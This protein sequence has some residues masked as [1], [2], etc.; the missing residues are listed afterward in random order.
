MKILNWNISWAKDI[1]PKIEC[2]RNQ[3]LGESFIVILQEVKP[4]AYNAIK[5]KLSD[6]ARIEYSL[7]YRVPSRYD[8]DSRK[9]GV[10]ILVSKD[11]VIEK[12]KVL[13]RALMPDRTL[14]VDVCYNNL[15]LRV[16]GLHSITGCQH[17]KAKEI[18]YFSFAEAID[19]YKP[20]VVGIDANEPQIDHYDVGRMKFFD[21]H[22][23]G[24]GCK[25]FFEVMTK[26]D[27]S[28]AYVKDYDRSKFVNGECLTTSHI[29]KRGRKKV[30]YDFLFI[31]EQ[32]IGDYSCEYKYEEAVLA[33]SDHA[34]ILIKTNNLNETF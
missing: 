17:G 34:V 7:S 22:Q 24:N 9:L 33:G 3:I 12:V 14:M 8:T 6:I 10:A 11:I 31:N 23:N 1:M 2:L 21:N 15:H 5:E 32:K 27:L 30:R 26:N 28:D 29:I 16:L 18:Q 25:T 20:D 4:N 13:D 19:T